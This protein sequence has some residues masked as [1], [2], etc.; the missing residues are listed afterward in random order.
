MKSIIYIAFVLFSYTISAQ[1]IIN[2]MFYNLL[3][4]PEAQSNNRAELLKNILTE[5]QPDIFMVC[6]L[7]NEVGADLVLNT[8]L[9]SENTSYSRAEFV[10]NQSSGSDLQQLIYYKTNKFSLESEEVI[11]TPVRDINKYVL[12]LNTIDQEADPIYIYVYVAHLKSSQGTDNKQLR[13]EMVTEFTNDLENI[14][15]NSFVIF[16]GDFN[17]YTSTEPAYQKLLD[18]NNAIQMI[19]PINTLGSWHN[20][21]DFQEIHSQSTRLSSGGFGAGAGG[22]L[23]DRFDF[24]TISE[25]IMSNPKLHYITDSYKSFGNNGNCY[26]IDINDESCI[27]T[28]SQELRDNLYNMSDHLPIIMQLETNKEFILDASNFQVSEIISIEKTL[29]E[30]FITIII[31]EVFTENISFTFYN[32]LGQIVLEYDSEGNKNNQIDV[33]FL[34]SGLFYIKT[35]IPNSPVYKFLKR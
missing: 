14:A 9:N 3:E 13:L 15:P 5:Y 22:G 20:N 32:S 34:Q 7:Q 29:V 25:T 10:H 33:S 2:T 19:D 26:N 11:T 12:K 28:F 6:E 17:L 30:D 24:I 8:S 27:G 16:S 35:S 4:F 23:D 31:S 1:E 18:P 21:E